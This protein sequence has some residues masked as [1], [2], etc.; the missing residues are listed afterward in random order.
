MP[1]THKKKLQIE[2]DATLVIPFQ[3]IPIGL[4]V[5]PNKFQTLPTDTFTG[6]QQGAKTEHT[7][8]KVPQLER[9]EDWDKGQF[10]DADTNL[11]NRHN[12]HAKSERIQK[13]Y[14]QH[15]LNLMD[16]Q[17]YPE[18]QAL[19]QLQYS[20]PNPD[21]YRPQLRKTHTHIDSHEPVGCYPPPPDP[22]DIHGW[23]TWVR[24]KCTYLHGHRLFPLSEKQEGE[25][26]MTKLQTTS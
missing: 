21:Y 22:A 15:L 6:P 25:K 4:T 23:H 10:A 17:Y 3:K 13:I 9:E 2:N 18:E 8:D 24:G 16:N 1:Q 5:S 19:T 12:T 11:I 26:K 7:I 20:I 14:T